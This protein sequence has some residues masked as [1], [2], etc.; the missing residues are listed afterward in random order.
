MPC[1]EMVRIVLPDY[2]NDFDPGRKE[3]GDLAAVGSPGRPGKVA[4]EDD[5]V[6]SICVGEDQVERAIGVVVHGVGFSHAIVDNSLAIRGKANASF[7]ILGSGRQ[8]VTL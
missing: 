4:S 6:A 2:V 7:A 8:W 3:A 1:R 5:G